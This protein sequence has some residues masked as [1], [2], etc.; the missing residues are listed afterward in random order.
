MKPDLFFSHIMPVVLLLAT[1]MLP[2]SAF[3]ASSEN[4]ICQLMQAEPELPEAVVQNTSATLPATPIIAWVEDNQPLK[5]LLVCVHGLGLHKGTYRQFAERMT[6]LG[7][8]VYAMDV[9][10]FGSFQEISDKPHLDFAGCLKDV[11]DVLAFV[12]KTHPGMPVFLLGESMGGGV[13]IQVAAKHPELVDGL[14]SS[15]PAQ[16]RYHKAGDAI[17]V[18]MSLL[19]GPNKQMNVVPI[20]VNRSTNKE[21]LRKQWLSDQLAR[22]EL[23]PT[24]L[25]KFDHFMQDNHKC[26]KLITKTPVLMLQGLSDKLVKHTGNETLITEIPCAD[27]CLVYVEGS[28]HL[29][30]EEGQ[31]DDSAIKSVSQWLD[32]H[33]KQRSG[34]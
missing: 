33:V 14:I 19:A 31:F 5:G 22:F 28:E 3:A 24:D 2:A 16:E 23:A 1:L 29:I 11:Q 13:V 21:Y 26:A 20:V 6:R 32:A 17:K 10:G 30:L 12:H 7:W 4:I 8:G 9:R 25:M 15:V 34:G 27:A 18:G